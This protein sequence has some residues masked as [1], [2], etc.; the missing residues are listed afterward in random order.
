MAR[1]SEDVIATPGKGEKESE[2]SATT[3]SN[4]GKWHDDVVAEK[5]IKKLIE[6]N[7]VTWDVMRTGSC[8]ALLRME[9]RR[10]EVWA[11]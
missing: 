6:E 11:T 2:E 10:R 4:V 8:T 9:R 3:R 7:Q 5:T 1:R